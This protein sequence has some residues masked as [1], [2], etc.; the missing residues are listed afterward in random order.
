MAEI[1]E[2]K[3]N[4]NIGDLSKDLDQAAKS[5]EKKIIDINLLSQMLILKLK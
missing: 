4:S 3:I 2:A 1:I 5:T